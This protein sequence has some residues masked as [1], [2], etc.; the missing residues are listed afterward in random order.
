VASKNLLR[1]TYCLRVALDPK[2]TTRYS[3]TKSALESILQYDS[4]PPSPDTYQHKRDASRV[5]LGT[6]LKTT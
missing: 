5:G 6:F 3:G 2:A 1:C 4:K